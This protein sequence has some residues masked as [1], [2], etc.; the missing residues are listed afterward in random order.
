MTAFTYTS[1]RQ[2]RYTD[3]RGCSDR[4][5]VLL[6]DPYFPL[7]FNSNL[8]PTLL[9]SLDTTIHTDDYRPTPTR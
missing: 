5:L 9:G 4:G 1:V 8:N 3:I 2:G 7:V 6:I